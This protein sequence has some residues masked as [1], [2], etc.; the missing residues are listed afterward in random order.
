MFSS[1]EKLLGLFLVFTTFY[2]I[3]EI[4][5]EFQDLINSKELLW[6]VSLEISFVI[7]SL[8]ALFYFSYIIYQQHQYRLKL[9]ENLVKTRRN[10]ES[11]NIKLQTGKKEFFKLIQWQFKQWQLTPTEQ[12]VALLMLKGCSIKE[13][14]K[15][16]TTKEKTIRNQASAIYDKSGLAG[17]HELS[18]WFFED[19]L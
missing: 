18:A 19:L 7:T 8:L 10:L 1:R 11:A 12:Q 14:A 9:E 17:R 16:R 6:Q 2:S 15:I 5:D 13:I 4:I 3:Y